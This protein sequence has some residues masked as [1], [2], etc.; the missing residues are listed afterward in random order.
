MFPRISTSSSTHGIRS[1]LPCCSGR[2]VLLFFLHRKEDQ[3][4]HDL[5]V[6][7]GARVPETNEHNSDQGQTSGQ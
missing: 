1:G 6:H 4:H 2:V 3:F 7:T 5:Y